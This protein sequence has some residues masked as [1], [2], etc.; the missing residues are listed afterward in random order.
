MYIEDKYCHFVRYTFW[1]YNVT[2]NVRTVHYNVTCNASRCI[3]M[4]LVMCHATQ[5][6]MQH[7]KAW[8]ST[9]RQ[10][11]PPSGYAFC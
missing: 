11:H 1:H 4:Q 8:V 2:C 9:W 6:A 10:V 5:S 3:I 7:R